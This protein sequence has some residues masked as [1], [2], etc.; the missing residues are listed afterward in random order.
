MDKLVGR[1]RNANRRLGE[2]YAAGDPDQIVVPIKSGVRP[3]RLAKLIPEVASHIRN[4]QRQLQTE[5]RGE[6][7]DLRNE[8][9]GGRRVAVNVSMLSDPPIL[10]ILLSSLRRQAVNQ[11]HGVYR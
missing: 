10:Q 5:R 9:I 8:R 1:L 3:Y 4:H 11:R 2:L 7:Q 6:E